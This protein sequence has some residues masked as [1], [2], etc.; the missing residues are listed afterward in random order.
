LTQTN[1]YTVIVS[2]GANIWETNDAC[3]FAYAR[4]AG[5]FDIRM[6]VHSV[7]PRLDDFTRVGLMARESADQAGSR[8]VMVAVNAE[9]SFQVL[10]RLQEGRLTASAPQ[11]PLP[12]AYGSNSWV[13]LQRVGAIFHAY[14]SSNGFD[15]AQLYQTTGGDT[16]F[17]DPIYVGVAASAHS[18]NSVSTNVLSNLGVTPTVPVNLTTTLALQAYRRGNFEEAADWCRRSL[19]Y[20][21]Y[22]AARVATARTILAMTCARLGRLEDAR[23]EL[24]QA[25]PLIEG[26]FPSGLAAGSEA[27]AFW[28][29]WAYAEILLRE[30]QLPAD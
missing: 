15:W 11:N 1:G 19:A 28:F 30:A 9:D 7:S 2:G 29:D 24:N 16:P 27:T 17:A 6:R 12:A 22:D 25:R 14:A 21:E 10:R 5:D 26:K 23:A 4:I 3:V 20:P 13:R 8:H 18:S